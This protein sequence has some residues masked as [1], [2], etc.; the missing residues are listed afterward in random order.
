MSPQNEALIKQESAE[1]HKNA[2]LHFL[3][4]FLN[5]KREA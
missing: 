5:K 3:F 2:T 1:V 4:F